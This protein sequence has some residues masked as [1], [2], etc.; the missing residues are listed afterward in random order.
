MRIFALA[1]VVVCSAAIAG[2]PSSSVPLTAAEPDPHA[3]FNR[4]SAR[5]EVLRAH[6]MRSQEEIDSLDNSRV[7]EHHRVTYQ[8]P[9]DSYRSPQD[10]AKITIP[11]WGPLSKVNAASTTPIAEK[12][13]SENTLNIPLRRDE[14]RRLLLTWDV[15]F[16]PSGAARGEQVP[17]PQDV[18]TRGRK[19]GMVRLE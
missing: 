17:G 15:W 16:G 10:A 14:R 11:G 7:L 2:I 5:A 1:A 3:L 12:I 9:S 13:G 8:W 4:L 6:G 18:Q 19:V